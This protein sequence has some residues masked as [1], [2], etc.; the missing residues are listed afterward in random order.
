M[1][2]ITEGGA[3]GALWE[4]AAAA[5][6]GLDIDLMKIPVRQETIEVCEVFGINPY[7]LISSGSLLVTT[8]DG[9]GLIRALEEAGI[10]AAIIGKMEDGNDRIIRNG[11]DRRYLEPPKTDEIYKVV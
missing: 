2:D 7:E 1:H 4:V 8:P 3:F 11:E 9:T 6:L 10:P 5:G